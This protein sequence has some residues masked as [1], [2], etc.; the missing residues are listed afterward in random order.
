MTGRPYV[1]PERPPP[2]WTW[3]VE[4]GSRPGAPEPG[5]HYLVPLRCD[6]C[7]EDHEPL[8]RC[9]TCGLDV[10]RHGNTEAGA[11]GIQAMTP[12]RPGHG[13]MSR[14]VHVNFA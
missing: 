1:Y 11:T 3:A 9:N 6:M 2:G 10:D 7:D 8:T 12:G 13:R 5:S 4:P 14:E